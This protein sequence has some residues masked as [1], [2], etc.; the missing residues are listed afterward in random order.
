MTAPSTCRRLGGRPRRRPRRFRQVCASPPSRA[1]QGVGAPRP[2]QRAA[3]GVGHGDEVYG[4]DTPAGGRRE[5]ESPNAL[6]A[7]A[8]HALWAGCSSAERESW[9]PRK[10]PQR[11]ET[12]QL[13]RWQQGPTPV[14]LLAP[15]I[16]H[17]M[18]ALAALAGGPARADRFQTTALDRL[19]PGLRPCRDEPGHA[20]AVIGERWAQV[21]FEESKGAV[22]LDQYEV[23]PGRLVSANHSGH[24]G[25][26]LPE[27]HSR[28][29]LR[30]T[31]FAPPARGKGGPTPGSLAGSCGS[32]PLVC[33]SVR[34]VRRLLWAVLR[35]PCPRCSSLGLVC[36]AAATSSSCQVHTI[37]GTGLA[38]A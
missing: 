34:E 1:G 22:G 7:S 30:A 23:G 18:T 15:P 36:A 3:G 5:R 26:C 17:P 10:G 24:V 9:S 35:P 32:V 33:L 12:A 31:P 25:A 29:H 8:K 14:R 19:L 13:R 21:R 11:L 2:G 20:G 37:N 4:S 6:T 38:C 28:C 16:N 27:R